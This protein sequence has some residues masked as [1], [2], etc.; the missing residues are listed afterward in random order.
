MR[1]TSP[2]P[3]LA[4]KLLPCFRHVWLG[5]LAIWPFACCSLLLICFNELSCD[6]IERIGKGEGSRVTKGGGNA[7]RGREKATK[8]KT[9][10]KAATAAICLLTCIITSAIALAHA[11]FAHFRPCPLPLRLHLQPLRICRCRPPYASP[12]PALSPLHLGWSAWLS[13]ILMSFKSCCHF[14]PCPH[15]TAPHRTT[16]HPLP[17]PA[18]STRGRRFIFNFIS[19][20]YFLS[21]FRLLLLLLSTSCD[22]LCCGCC[23][24]FRHHLYTT[25]TT[26]FYLS[27]TH[28][29]TYA[30][31]HTLVSICCC[32]STRAGSNVAYTQRPNPTRPEA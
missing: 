7:E 18:Q 32:N 17:N 3:L 11:A 9:L 12:C 22:L 31:T 2:P 27:H 6:F 10:R 25:T 13:L 4:T 19:F 29:H 30:Y 15:C 26:E 1:R 20:I 5:H 21:K 23:F 28:T 14:L 16:P 8:G 24:C